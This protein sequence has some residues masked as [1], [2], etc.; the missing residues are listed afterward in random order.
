[1]DAD[2]LKNL[3]K[4]GPPK[5][6]DMTQVMRRRIMD[7]GPERIVG[8][9][10]PRTGVKNMHRILTLHSVGE[11][12]EVSPFLSEVYIGDNSQDPRGTENDPRARNMASQLYEKGQWVKNGLYN[13]D[14]LQTV[15]E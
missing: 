2:I 7:M 11:K 12:S 4:N 1:M 9:S 5:Q 14:G 6:F 15:A 13:N 3:K 10:A 8:D